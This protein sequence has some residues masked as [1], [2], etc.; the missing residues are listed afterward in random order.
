MPG[1]YDERGPC[2]TFPVLLLL[3]SQHLPLGTLTGGILSKAFSTSCGAI[4]AL[5]C[6]FGLH[7]DGFRVQI[8]VWFMNDPDQNC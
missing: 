3:C 5:I 8:L 4:L 1:G 2:C 6:S 7:H